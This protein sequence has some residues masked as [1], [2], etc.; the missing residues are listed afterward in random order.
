MS[1]KC[2]TDYKC[3]QPS[4]K[5]AERA[6]E[7]KYEVRKPQI[8]TMSSKIAEGNKKKKKKNQCAQATNEEQF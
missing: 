4:T 7:G 1:K 8:K 3:F 6:Q 2:E 5:V